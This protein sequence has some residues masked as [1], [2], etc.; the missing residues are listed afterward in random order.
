MPPIAVLAVWLLVL[1][2]LRAAAQADSPPLLST[3]ISPTAS[4][5]PTAADT[6]APTPTAT[7]EGPPPMESV[8]KVLDDQVAAW[9]LGDL[10]AFMHGYW[11]SPGLTFF[12]GAARTQGWQATLDRY[13][14][15]Y[16][17]EGQPMGQ[18]S[19]PQLD[20]QPLGSDAAFVRGEWQLV[21]GNETLGGLFTLVFR[22]FPEGWK[23]VH[24]HTS[25]R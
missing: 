11:A 24:D 18:V 23:I 22:R 3:N 17:Q 16:Q 2:P 6:V 4:P 1:L 12:S 20:I 8:R 19:F 13:R 9:N 5:S 14:N 7:P 25:A 21:R 10:E 15:K